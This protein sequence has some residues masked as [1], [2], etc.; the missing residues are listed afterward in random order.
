MLLEN[1]ETVLGKR[2]RNNSQYRVFKTQDSYLEPF[3]HYRYFVFD[4]SFFVSY[5]VEN[6]QDKIKL[7]IF[8]DS[9]TTVYL[10]IK[11][12]KAKMAMYKKCPKK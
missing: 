3:R 1:M 11:A 4:V 6:I 8:R 5:I 2:L 7:W 12:P 9:F 10:I